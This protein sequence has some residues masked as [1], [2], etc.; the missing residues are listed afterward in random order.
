M[1]HQAHALP[2]NT[3]A[4]QYKYKMSYHDHPQRKDIFRADKGEASKEVDYF[5]RALAQRVQEFA[6]TE[7]AKFPPQ[8]ELRARAEAWTA[9]EPDS[10]PVYPDAMQ[11]RYFDHEGLEGR[12]DLP[13]G[14][15][16]FWQERQPIAKWTDGGGIGDHTQHGET[17][18]L[19]MMEAAGAPPA[20]CADA[21]RAPLKAEIMESLLLV[22]NHPGIRLRDFLDGRLGIRHPVSRIAEV[23]L[24]VYLY[25][26]L[27]VVLQAQGSEACAPA[28]DEAGEAVPGRRVYMGLQSYRYMLSAA[29]GRYDDDAQNL[30]HCAFFCARGA[31]GAGEPR[32]AGEA[33]AKDVLADLEGLREYLK[34]V[35]RILVVYDLV[36]RE[37]GGD[38]GLEEVCKTSLSRS[39]G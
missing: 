2:W 23:A 12:S 7:R 33:E 19:M 1:A 34:G 31:D 22:A 18:K 10:R 9:A 4:A 20:L 13:L 5:G 30:V 29:T 24:R 26:N 15:G 27:L 35:W 8:A 37:A 38:P 28:R 32:W 39:F 3:L 25:L 11:R 36:A 16:R 14:P 17:V 21:G 6:A